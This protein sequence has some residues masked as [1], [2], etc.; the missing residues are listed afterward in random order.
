MNF[1]F[2]DK[3]D[4]PVSKD[5]IDGIIDI[6]TFNKQAMLVSDPFRKSCINSISMYAGYSICSKDKIL[7]YGSVKFVNGDTEGEQKFE[8]NTLAELYNKIAVFCDKLHG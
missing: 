3:K 8:A 1:N 2:F 4:V 7:V 5:V 6:E